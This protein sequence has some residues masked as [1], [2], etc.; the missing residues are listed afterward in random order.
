MRA[1]PTDAALLLLVLVQL[2]WQVANVNG[3]NEASA[4]AG[5]LKTDEF[6]AV[7][8]AGGSIYGGYTKYRSRVAGRDIRVFVLE[9]A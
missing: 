3:Q 5:A 9:T 1:T 7:F 4:A 2:F 8:A 6:E